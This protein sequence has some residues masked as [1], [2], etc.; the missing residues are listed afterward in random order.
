MY[1]SLIVRLVSCYLYVVSRSGPSTQRSVSGSTVTLQILGTPRDIPSKY[2]NFPERAQ[3]KLLNSTPASL[4][5]L[6]TLGVSS[7]LT[8][9]PPAIVTV[10]KVPSILRNEM[11]L[12]SGCHATECSLMPVSVP[13]IDVAISCGVVSWPSNVK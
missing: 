10:Q 8:G 13:L 3:R 4:S 9:A 6:S 5:W 2:R 12:P 11:R 7:D 1:W